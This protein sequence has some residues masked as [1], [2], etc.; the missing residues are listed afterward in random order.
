[1][2]EE[3][4]VR[5]VVPAARVV[6]R[7]PDECQHEC[8]KRGLDI[9]GG[10]QCGRGRPAAPTIGKRVNHMKDDGNRER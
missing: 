10:D 7:I 9:Q 8:R 6:E 4:V 1:V 2:D 3:D 5:A